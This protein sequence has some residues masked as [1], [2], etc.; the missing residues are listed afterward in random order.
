MQ[1]GPDS[2][3]GPAPQ[4]TPAGAPRTTHHLAGDVAPGHTPAQDV[5]D[6][7]QRNPVWDP[8]SPWVAVFS[9]RVGRQQHLVISGVLIMCGTGL[10]RYLVGDAPVAESARYGIEAE[11]GDVGLAGFALLMLM[12]RAFSSGCTALTG[13]EAIS[14]G[15]PAFRKP[16]SANAAATMLAMG[17]IA[18]TMFVGV[19][20]LAMVAKVHMVEDPCQLSGLADC[21]AHT[22]RTVIAQLAASVFGGAASFGFYY[23]QAATAL[24]LILAANTA[25]NGFPM[26]V[27]ILAQHRHLPRQLHKAGTGGCC[28]VG[29]VFGVGQAGV[30]VHGSVQA[31]DSGAVAVLASGCPAQDLVTATVGDAA[32]LLDVMWTSSP[33]RARS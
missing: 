6:A 5:D 13:V 8:K 22:Q 10:I 30:V 12:L 7:G 18:V 21:E 23:I 4:P 26:L 20:T 29:E 33:A 11:P 9:C 1:L 25:F 16:K 31:G 19:T 28:F 14:N 17:A 2:G 32:E 3:F 15:V 27:D 24:I